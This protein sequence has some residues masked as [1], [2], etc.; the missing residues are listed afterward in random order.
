MGGLLPLPEQAG[1]VVDHPNA[2]RPSRPQKKTPARVS[3]CRMGEGKMGAGGTTR[4]L[5]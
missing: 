2:K 5:G 4:L 1:R 3:Y